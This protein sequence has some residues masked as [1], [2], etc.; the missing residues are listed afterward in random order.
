MCPSSRCSAATSQ[1]I[2]AARRAGTARA[3][4]YDANA[5]AATRDKAT[6]LLSGAVAAVAL[7]ASGGTLRD[8]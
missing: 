6:S 2:P 1:G 5:A 4:T 8:A 3:A 7:A